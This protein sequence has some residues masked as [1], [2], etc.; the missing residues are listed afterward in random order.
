[1]SKAAGFG[2]V[3][4]GGVDLAQHEHGLVLEGGGG[5]GVRLVGRAGGAHDEGAVQAHR[6]LVLGVGH[7]GG[8][9]EVG[10]R[11]A[12]RE[13]VGPGPAGGGAGQV[14]DHLLALDQQAA[15]LSHLVVQGD[16]DLVTLVDDEGRA[17]GPGHR[18][19]GVVVAPDRHRLA[20][21]HHGRRAD[22]GVQVEAPGGRGG[23][24][25]RAHEDPEEGQCGSGH[26]GCGGPA[27]WSFLASSFSPPLS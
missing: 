13:R 7:G 12:G 17:A 2:G 4:E 14:R 10:A 16:G 8:L 19:V 15:G 1:M 9:V 3:V 21:G 11:V 24:P 25:G 18:C 22:D 5:R 23:G 27:S 6:H 26:E 20:A